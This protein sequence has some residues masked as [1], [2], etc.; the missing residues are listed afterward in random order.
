MTI[1][2]GQ[3]NAGTF[4]PAYDGNGNLMAL[5]NA[6]SGAI[7]A[8]YQYRQF[9]PTPPSHRLAR[10]CEQYPFLQQVF[11]LGDGVVLLWQA[12]LQPRHGEVA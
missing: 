10:P 8:R 3:P 4:F 7:A 1:P 6:A 2:N 11:R 12:L 5:V 9:R